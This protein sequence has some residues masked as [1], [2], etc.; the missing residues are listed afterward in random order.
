MYGQVPDWKA[1]SVFLSSLPDVNLLNVVH[2]GD[3]QFLPIS[4]EKT[5]K[6]RMEDVLLIFWTIF[7]STKIQTNSSHFVKYYNISTLKTANYTE[8]LIFYVDS[9]EFYPST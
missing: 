1:I 9:S 4:P 6:L 7:F 5:Q 3:S 2:K 8:R